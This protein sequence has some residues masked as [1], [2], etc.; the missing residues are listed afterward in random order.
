MQTVTYHNPSVLQY[1]FNQSTGG[2]LS[3]CSCRLLQAGSPDSWWDNCRLKRV[4][5]LDFRRRKIM[6]SDAWMRQFYTHNLGINFYINSSQTFWELFG[7]D[8]R[9]VRN[10]HFYSRIFHLI[11]VLSRLSGNYP[12]FQFFWIFVRTFSSHVPPRGSKFKTVLCFLNFIP[13]LPCVLLQQQQQQQQYWTLNCYVEY[14]SLWR[15][16]R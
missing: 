8:Q 14:C 5:T 9:V 13:P 2:L 3:L 11:I 12:Q 15:T 10:R 16:L 4:A 7:V 1:D 6:K